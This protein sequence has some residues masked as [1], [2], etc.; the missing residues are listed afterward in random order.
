MADIESAWTSALSALASGSSGESSASAASLSVLQQRL[1][2]VVHRKR[3]IQQYLNPAAEKPSNVADVQQQLLLD[4]PSAAEL[5]RTIRDAVLQA[6][7][8][9]V[10]SACVQ[11]KGGADVQ[12]VV[13][14]LRQAHVCIEARLEEF[15]NGTNTVVG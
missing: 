4:Q 10:Q 5:D 8:Q 2:R 12:S 14:K 11:L 1:L 15:S 6:A 13:L 9:V 7:E 3:I